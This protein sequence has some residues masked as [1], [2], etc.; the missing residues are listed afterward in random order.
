MKDRRGC[1]KQKYTQGQIIR[2]ELVR[3][4]ERERTN[5]QDESLSAR[6]IILNEQQVSEWSEPPTFLPQC[7]FETITHSGTSVRCAGCGN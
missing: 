2:A 6:G 5:A 3:E 7:N 4:R 1:E